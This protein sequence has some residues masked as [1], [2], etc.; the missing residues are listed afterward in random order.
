M[1]VCTKSLFLWRHK[2]VIALRTVY[3]SFPTCLQ[4]QQIP[5]KLGQAKL[6]CFLTWLMNTGLYLRR[7][8][9]AWCLCLALS[10]CAYKKVH[11][12]SELY[13]RSNQR[14]GEETE[15]RNRHTTLLQYRI[16][17]AKSWKYVGGIHR[18]FK[19]VLCIIYVFFSSEGKFM[20]SWLIISFISC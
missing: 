5:F 13:T 14:K 17:Q 4:L 2:K 20:F 6:S 15:S 11:L 19:V 16:D 9:V 18:V 12:L 7:L 10:C 1:R 3:P 8:K